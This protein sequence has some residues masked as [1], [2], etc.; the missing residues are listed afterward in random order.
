MAYIT[1]L[2]YVNVFITLSGNSALLVVTKLVYTST[3]ENGCSTFLRKVYE[4]IPDCT[5]PNP[6]GNILQDY[7][8]LKI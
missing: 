3:P 2:F 4:L 7:K 5:V 8:C 1:T 6:D